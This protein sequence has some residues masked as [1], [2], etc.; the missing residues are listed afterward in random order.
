MA[1]RQRTHPVAADVE[2]PAPPTA[3]LVPP[4][5]LRSDKGHPPPSR[6]PPPLPPLTTDHRPLPIIQP[7]PPPTHDKKPSR[8]CLLRCMCWTLSL[9]IILSIL[10]GALVGIIFLA[11]KPQVPKYSVDSL[12]VSDLRLNLDMT[13][14]ARFDVKITAANPNKKIGIFYEKGSK[15]SVWYTKTKLCQGSLPVFYQGHQ[16]TTKLNVSLTGQTQ[17][18]STLM[19]ALQEQQQT[20]RIPLD[21][22]VDVPAAIKLGKLKL[23]K[24]RLL[25]GCELIVDSLSTNSF[26]SIKASNC[27]FKRLKL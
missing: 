23:P 5:S 26:V 12:R 16:N 27:R 10:V 15:L 2:A 1:D 3:P 17:A 21:L 11:F 18:G 19:S 4:G 22:R 9:L 7:L 25:V 13:L 8:S 14:Y 20:G 24:V 6:P